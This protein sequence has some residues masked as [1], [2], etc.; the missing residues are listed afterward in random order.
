MASI[1]DPQIVSGTAQDS[2]ARLRAT[3]N[4]DGTYTP[5][6]RLDD[7]FFSITSGNVPGNSL[8]L[9]S[10]RNPDIDTASVPEDVWNGGGVYTG[11][12][13]TSSEKVTVVSS[14]ANDAAAGT[15][16][17]TV[18][19]TGL[20][21]NYAVQ[22]ETLTL[23]GTTPVLSVGTYRRVHT[24]RVV[25]AGSGGVNEGTLTCAH[26]TTTANVFFVMPVGFNQTNV[27]GYTVP[28]GFTAYMTKLQVTVRGNSTAQIQGSIWTRTFGEVFRSRRP[29]GASGAGPYIDIITGGLA[30][31]EKSDIVVR[32]T[33]CDANNTD[34]VA[35]YDL[36]LV[37]N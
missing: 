34:V 4:D 12:P 18:S 15:G 19:I 11:F 27:S 28:A 22:S 6:V 31:T 5:Q 21:A 32:I 23:N 2:V 20:D 37:Q 9:K 30:F 1:I 7:N 17:R 26:Q 16:A 24:A 33:N 35:S 36:V 13:L 3:G 25:S 14:S 8:T 10:G 29:F